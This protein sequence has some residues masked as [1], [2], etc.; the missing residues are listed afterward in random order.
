MNQDVFNN[1]IYCLLEYKGDI[2]TEEIKKISQGKIRL[3]KAMAV[4]EN[5]LKN[6]RLFL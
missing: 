6:G 3:E 1:F 4:L 5:P 2:T